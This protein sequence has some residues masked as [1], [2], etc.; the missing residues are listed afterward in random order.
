MA[1]VAAA[2]PLPLTALVSLLTGVGGAGE[3]A[4]AVAVGDLETLYTGGWLWANLNGFQLL[5]I[6]SRCAEAAGQ[7]LPVSHELRENPGRRS[8][9]T[10]GFKPWTPP[11]I[12]Q[13]NTE[14][15]GEDVKRDEAS[16]FW[17]SHPP[18]TQ[19]LLDR[20]PKHQICTAPGGPGP[21]RVFFPKQ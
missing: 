17:E 21:A 6:R 9:T 2:S 12:P 11:A 3:R 15:P 20:S 16:G 18:Y 10:R 14:D 7:C 5:E 4:V 13:R 8:C 19:V 1:P